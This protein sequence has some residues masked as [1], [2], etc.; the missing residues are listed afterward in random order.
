[1]AQTVRKQKGVTVSGTD[2]KVV[3][4]APAGVSHVTVIAIQVGNA[5]SNNTTMTARWINHD[6]RVYLSS[7]YF[8][9]GRT[10]KDKVYSF[11][12]VTLLES[13]LIPGAAALSII[14]KSLYLSPRDV[15][16]VKG[17]SVNLGVTVTVDEVYADPFSDINVDPSSVEL[18]IGTTADPEGVY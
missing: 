1:M 17:N 5:T 9:D 15:V 12:T 18:L 3:Y 16:Q 2:Y 13:A 6:A 11:P 14:D 8:G 7:T 4:A 10:E